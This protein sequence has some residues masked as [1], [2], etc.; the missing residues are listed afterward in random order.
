MSSPALKSSARLNELTAT[1]VVAAVKAGRTTC[2]AVTRACLERIEARDRDV[3]AWQYI[4]PDQ[5][6]AE[7]R[8]RDRGDKSGALVGVPFNVKDIIDT[9]DMPTEYGSPIYKDFR[10]RA[11][12][13]CV[14]MSRKAGAV[15]LG[16]AVTTEFANFHPSRTKNPLDLT[17]TPGGSSAGSAASVADY[18]CA[19]SVG[20]QTSGSTV[21]P[22]GFCGVIGFRP[23]FGELR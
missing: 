12:A 7:A 6:I 22:A 19:L 23:T 18:M 5:A 14:A 9:G 13:S 3:Q 20:S 17:R 11:D 8:A 16:K 15:L 21:R 4:N 1:E 10:P 2:E